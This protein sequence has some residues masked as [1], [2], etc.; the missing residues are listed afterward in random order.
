MADT[1]YNLRAYLLTSV[2]ITDLVADRIH[3][4]HV[5]E[6]RKEDYIWLRTATRQYDHHLNSPAGEAPR[7]I[8]YDCECC[9]R[10]LDRSAAIADAVRNLF[11]YAGT[12]G[13]STTKGAFVNDQDETYI[14]INEMADEGVHVQAVQIEVMP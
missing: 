7:A 8:Y 14:P 11:P 5:P 3:Q 9:S 1:A 4:N 6:D 12:M 10:N 2:A 13:D